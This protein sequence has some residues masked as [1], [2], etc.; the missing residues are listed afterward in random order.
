MDEAKYY[1][2]FNSD[3]SPLINANFF[4]LVQP[5]ICFSRLAASDFVLNPY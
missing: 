4:F 5:L 2:F 1:S 3:K